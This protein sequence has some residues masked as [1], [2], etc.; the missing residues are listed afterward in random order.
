MHLLLVALVV[1]SQLWVGSQGAAAGRAHRAR[2]NSATPTKLVIV[3]TVG[4]IYQL[5]EP[6]LLRC[7]GVDVKVVK[8]LSGKYAEPTI[9]FAV[10]SP[11][12]SGV[13]LGETYKIEAEW[14][15]G[16]WLVPPMWWPKWPPK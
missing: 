9:T 8:V 6:R 1:T 11:A 4:S 15:D 14:K 3:G 2:P 13:E 7:W 10:H 5:D 16:E 12:K